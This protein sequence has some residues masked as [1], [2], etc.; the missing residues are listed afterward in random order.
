MSAGSKI[1]LGEAIEVMNERLKAVGIDPTVDSKI[2]ELGDSTTRLF[3][4]GFDL[5]LGELD[6]LGLQLEDQTDYLATLA[7]RGEL[8]PASIWI[9]GL[10]VGLIA[11]GRHQTA[12]AQVGS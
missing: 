9:Q 5:D 7:E 11:A 1:K 12:P 4:S 6:R 8:S 3:L 2:G 10:L